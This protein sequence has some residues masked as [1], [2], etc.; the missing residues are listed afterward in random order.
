M[1]DK[2]VKRVPGSVCAGECLYRGVFVPGRL[3]TCMH[4]S[5]LE[6]SPSL[7]SVM[8]MMQLWPRSV[9]LAASACVSLVEGTGVRV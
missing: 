9:S 4:G 7:K 2:A 5:I 6:S 3:T 8:Q 1:R